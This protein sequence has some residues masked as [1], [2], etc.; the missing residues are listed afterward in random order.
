MP[1]QDS[2]DQTVGTGELG[3]RA[4]EQ[5][6]WDR[7]GRNNRPTGQARQDRSARGDTQD[8]SARKGTGDRMART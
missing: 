5:D 7:T 8:S 6:S 4:I 2:K 1:G 3:T